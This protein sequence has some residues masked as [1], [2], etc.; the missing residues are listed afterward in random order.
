MKLHTNRAVLADYNFWRSYSGAEV[1]LL[2]K[3][4][5]KGKMSGYEIKLGQKGARKGAKI[6][7]SQY[8]IP[9]KVI[10]RENYLNFIT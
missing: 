9:T 6:F 8:K 5:T 4:L 3:E 2:E 10:N 1:D 7:S